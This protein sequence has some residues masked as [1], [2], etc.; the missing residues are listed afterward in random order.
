MKSKAAVRLRICKEDNLKASWIHCP[1]P[2]YDCFYY[3]LVH[4]LWPSAGTYQH[5]STEVEAAHILIKFVL[6]NG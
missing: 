6:Q 1:Y 5:I 3:L 4:C 2:I